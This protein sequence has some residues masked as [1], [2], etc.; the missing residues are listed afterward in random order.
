MYSTERYAMVAARVLVAMIFMLSGLN[1][2]GQTLAVHEMAADG[3][4]PPLF[5]L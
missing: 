1:I 4:P 5:L 3:F 2:I